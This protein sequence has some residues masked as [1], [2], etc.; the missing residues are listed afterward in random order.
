MNQQLQDYETFLKA[1]IAL[2][3]HT[4][5]DV[6]DSAIH[7]LAK[8]H[9]RK[10]IRWNCKGGQRGIFTAFGLGKSIIQ[11]ETCRLCLEYKGGC[12]LIV[13]P[14]GVRQEFIRDAKMVDTPIRFVRTDAEVA[15][16]GLYLTNYESVRDG[17]I[18]PSGF[19]VIS[20]DEAAIL[21]GFGG[22]LTFREFMRL[23]EGTSVFRFVA[24]ATPSPNEYIE[25]LCYAAFLGIMEVSEA[26]TR[27]FKRDSTKAD[28]LTLY[29]HK[30]EEFWLWVSSWA[31]FLQQ[32]SDLCTH[33]SHF[34]SEEIN[35][36]VLSVQ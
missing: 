32:P 10:I 1:K 4:G 29:P 15:H 16:D 27:F 2:A 21:R 14:L 20:L 17:K 18:D 35:G 5:F 36:E 26:K 34:Q 12:G 33:P 3:K 24:T 11:I 13:C 9:Q 6:S 30:V 7:P 31:I 19:T 22:S 28:K 23:F 8:P 25:L